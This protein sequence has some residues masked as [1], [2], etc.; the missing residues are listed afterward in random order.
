MHN[1]S[2]ISNKFTHTCYCPDTPQAKANT[3]SAV[4][5]AVIAA[6]CL[7]VIIIVPASVVGT[8]DETQ[9]VSQPMHRFGL[10]RTVWRT[11]GA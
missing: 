10:L 6:I 9:R 5:L 7:A 3:A 2:L 11:G 4:T 1:C 8:R